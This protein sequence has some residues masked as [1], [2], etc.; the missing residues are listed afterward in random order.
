MHRGVKERTFARA[1]GANRRAAV[2]AVSAGRTGCHNLSS[3]NLTLGFHPGPLKRAD[4]TCKGDRRG[5]ARRLQPPAGH[6]AVIGPQFRSGNS[7]TFWP[8]IRGEPV[9][10]CLRKIE[11][12]RAVLGRALRRTVR[13]VENAEFEP[14]EASPA[15]GDDAA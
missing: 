8:L 2:E 14:I 15:K 13:E 6:Q 4:R 9:R 10:G 7:I 12:R 3:A 1:Y 5:D 11:R